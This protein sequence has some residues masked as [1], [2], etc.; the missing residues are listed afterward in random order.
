MEAVGCRWYHTS[1]L[2]DRLCTRSSQ[3]SHSPTAHR[4]PR[5]PARANRICTGRPR[6]LPTQCRELPPDSRPLTCGIGNWLHW[7]RGV[8]GRWRGL[9]HGIGIAQTQSS[10]AQ[11]AAGV[12]A[13]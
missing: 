6:W 8:I 9:L 3:P 1:A 2:A 12:D 11:T 5:A 7:T 4:C 13:L 10:G